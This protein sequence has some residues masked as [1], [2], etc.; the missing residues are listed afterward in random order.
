MNGLVRL[1]LASDLD[2]TVLPHHACSVGEPR[3]YPPALRLFQDL[4][5]RSDV[6]LALISGRPLDELYVWS[7][8]VCCYRAGSFGAEIDG[9]DAA[10][11]LRSARVRAHA[12]A[13]VRASAGRAGL[14]LERKP[15]GY[16]LRGNIASLRARPVVAS[17]T[18]WALDNGFQILHL[19]GAV[20]AV[21]KG[22]EKRIA[23]AWIARATCAAV[24]V[25]AGDD[26]SD[27]HAAAWAATRGYGFC[28]S[29]QIS[30]DGYVP[31]RTIPALWRHVRTLCTSILG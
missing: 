13:T 4:G 25:F 8:D 11:L 30:I 2:G 22:I 14:L 17:F 10:P 26:A 24:V 21:P 20:E 12:P 31:I 23:L 29:R 7:R 18:A 16:A 28:L 1:L 6:A 3:W 19:R 27:A 5:E 9:P 15:H